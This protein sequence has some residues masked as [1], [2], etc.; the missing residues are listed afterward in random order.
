M[1]ASLLTGSASGEWQPPGERDRYVLV[2]AGEVELCLRARGDPAVLI[3]AVA[4]PGDFVL[5][6]REYELR[7]I[8]V[9]SPE[10]PEYWMALI[11]E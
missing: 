5:W 11:F 10:P 9:L 6:S 7:T 2:L 4:H 1:S 3:R 8:P